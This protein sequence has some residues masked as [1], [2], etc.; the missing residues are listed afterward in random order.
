V[1]LLSI[2]NRKRQSHEIAKAMRVPIQEIAKKWNARVKVAEVPPG[3]PVISTLVA[4]VYGPDYQR[5]I[6]VAEQIREI[7]EGTPGVVDVDWYV[8]ADQKK[9][10]FQV[11][12][13]KAAMRG[14]SPE[15]VSQSVALAL[16]GTQVGLLHQ[17]TER[18]DVPIRV[19]LSRESRSSEG[20][21]RGLYL[22]SPDGAMVPLG[23]LA[24]VQEGTIDKSVYRKNQREVVYV[25]ADVAGAEESPVYA[26]GTLGKKIDALKIPE[27]YGIEQFTAI[28][29]PNAKKL[30]VKWDGEWHITYEVFRDLGLAFAAVLV[31]IY[32]LVVGWF[33]SFK[34]PLVIM[35]PIPLTLVGILPA[36]AAM[37]AFF[38]ATSMI[39]FIAGA[40]IIVRNSIILVDFIKL[41]REQG[42]A[43]EEAV[44]DAGAVRFRPMLLTA[45]AVVVGA[46]VIL[47]DPIFQGLAISLMAGEVASTLLSRIAVPVLYYMSERGGK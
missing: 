40:G 47:F 33:G 27:G 16:G 17:A 30:A 8:V 43:L 4:E 44:V 12:Q 28:Q 1:N 6:E 10:D 19:Q 34:T 32:V 45:A 3:P 26:I 37:G 29:P 46:G 31:L 14:I 41:R 18:E 9:L 13:D 38:T 11:Q 5:Q 7:F 35:A 24:K 42:M 36:H 21:L 22:N 20:S 23:E 39:G 15:Q 25:T 2:E